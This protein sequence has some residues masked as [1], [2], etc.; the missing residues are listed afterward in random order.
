MSAGLVAVIV[1]ACYLAILLGLGLFSSRF[2]K[3]TAADFFLASHG[4][5]PFL[6]LMSL[7]S[8]YKI[9]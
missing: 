5:G 2:F 7:L 9:P 3:G 1:V 6:L 8:C 4:I